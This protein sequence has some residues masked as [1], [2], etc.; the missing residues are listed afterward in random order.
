VTTT[1]VRSR[2]QGCSLRSRSSLEKVPEFQTDPD[3]PVLLSKKQKNSAPN[4][5][6]RDCYCCF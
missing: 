5:F 1:R 2:H 4:I 3:T 6:Q